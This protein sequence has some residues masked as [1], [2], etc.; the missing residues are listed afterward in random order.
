VQ[1]TDSHGNS[2][3]A[4]KVIIPVPLAVL[5]ARDIH[6]TGFEQHKTKRHQ[7]YRNGLWHEDHPEVQQPFLGCRFSSS[8]PPTRCL[9][10]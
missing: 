5:K 3:S 10:I 4:D 1:L 7:Q 8:M 2:Y 6:F 9:N